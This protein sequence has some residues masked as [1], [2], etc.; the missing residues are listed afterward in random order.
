MK[1]SGLAKG[2]AGIKIGHVENTPKGN[3][4]SNEVNGGARMS[5]EDKM[6]SDIE[7]AVTMKQGKNHVNFHVQAQDDKDAA[8]TTSPDNT[9][10]EEETDSNGLARD[11]VISVPKKLALNI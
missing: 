8:Y 7:N 10:R 2:P 9:G 11:I 6:R 1:L 5:K 3:R 4:E